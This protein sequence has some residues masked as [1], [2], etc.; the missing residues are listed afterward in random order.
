[1]DFSDAR[2]LSVLT[3]IRE[4]IKVYAADNRIKYIQIIKNEGQNA[5]ASIYHSHWQ[6]FA[7]D[8]LPDTQKK[9]CTRLWN[10]SQIIGSCFLCDIKKDAGL[11][12]VYENPLFLAYSPY[13]SAY[14]HMV[15][16]LPK[17]HIGDFLCFDDTYLAALGDALKKII[18]ALELINPGLSYNICFQNAPYNVKKEKYK[19]S[20]FFIQ[21]IPRIG[22]LAGFEFSTGCFI[23]SVLPEKS[24]ASL[25]ELLF[26][27]NE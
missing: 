11:L 3:A 25:K 23:N 2:L 18:T 20:H 7:I 4:R 10:Y 17:A 8:F 6:L 26:S 22:N 21:I 19:A 5:G 1:M 14:P 9:M 13:A 16:I 12:T 15:Q 27:L 24:R